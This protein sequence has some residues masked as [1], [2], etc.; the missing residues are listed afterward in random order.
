LL[1]EPVQQMWI[2]YPEAERYSGLSHTTLWRYVSSGELKAARVGRSV[3]IHATP[4]AAELNVLANVYRFILD[5]HAKKMAAEPDSCNDAAIVRNTEGV[6][7]VEQRPDT[8][9]EVT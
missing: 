8:S 4:E 3:R 7:H 9:L 6:S 2:N 1:K 5:C